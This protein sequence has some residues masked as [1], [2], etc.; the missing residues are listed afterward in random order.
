M[1]AVPHGWRLA[2]WLGAVVASTLVHDAAWLGGAALLVLACSG[3]GR[4]AL[5]MRATLTA[6]LD[7][8]YPL[9]LGTRLL[10]LSLLTAWMLRDVDLHRALSRWP[11]AQRWLMIVRGQQQLFRRLAGDYQ[12]AQRSRTVVPPR[13]RHRYLAVTAT[14]LAALDKAVHNAEHVTDAMR[15]RGGLDD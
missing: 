13:L 1:H 11:R 7:W 4:R 6:T 15:S 2:G 10:L 8:R 5:L 12:Q 9:L 14:A 3:A